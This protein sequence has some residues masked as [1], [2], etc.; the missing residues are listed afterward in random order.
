MRLNL[1]FSP[2][3][4]VDEIIVVPNGKVGNTDGVLRLNKEGFEIMQMLQNDTTIEGIVD[5]LS[6]KYKN[7]RNELDTYVR[8][9]IQKLRS[10]N[11]IQE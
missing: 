5:A 6:K 10:L 4:L 3:D 8:N 1:T 9:A 11:M 7:E 2:V